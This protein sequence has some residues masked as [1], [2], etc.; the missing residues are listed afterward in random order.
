MRWEQ[1]VS[2]AIRRAI[3]AG[4][5]DPA[6]IAWALHWEDG[7]DRSTASATWAEAGAARSAGAAVAAHEA[8]WGCPA[9]LAGAPPDLT[10]SRGEW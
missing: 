5:D 6:W 1:R 8:A 10:A 7:M 9:S 2:R 4:A 3:H